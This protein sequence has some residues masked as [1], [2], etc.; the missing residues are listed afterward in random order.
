MPFVLI[1]GTYHVKGF[2]PDGDSLRFLPD[3][4]ADWD[5]LPGRPPRLNARGMAQLRLEGIDALET[6]FAAG[7]PLGTVHQPRALADA[8]R[9]RLLGLLGIDGVVLAANGLTVAEANDAKPGWILTREVEMNGRPV[10]FA[11]PGAPPAGLDGDEAFLDPD[12]LRAGVNHRLLAEGLAYP[13]YYTTLFHD[14]REAMTLAVAEARAA[15]RGVWADDATMGVELASLATITDERPILPKLFRRLASYIAQNGG[16]ID[17]TGFRA[18]LAA[19]RERVIVLGTGQT[20][21]F[22]DVVAAEGRT[23]G[24]LHD[25]ARLVFVPRQAV[26]KV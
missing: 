18:W 23:V 2:Q 3:D 20:T 11:F 25:P 8:A 26:P 9:D 17:L 22:D 15:G 5:L 1:R 12:L 7:G 4:L 6:H 19:D 14:L 21:G 24:L 10:A 16:E 13:I